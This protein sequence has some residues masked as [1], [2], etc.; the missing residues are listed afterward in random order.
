MSCEA[1]AGRVRPSRS[2][3]RPERDSR[4]RGSTRN[5]SAAPPW[6]WRPMRE[7]VVPTYFTEHEP[8]GTALDRYAAAGVRLVELHG[9]APRTHI[10]L[11]DGAA[12]DALSRDRHGLRLAVHSVHAPYSQPGED[13]WD[14]SQPDEGRRSAALRNHGKVI[15]SAARLGANHVVIHPGVRQRGEGRLE[16]CRASMACL[17]ESAREAGTRVA[18]ENLPPDF[19]GSSV[20]EMIHLLAG[21]DPAAAGVCL[22]TGHAM[23]GGD[24]PVAYVRALGDRIFGLHWHTNDGLGDAHLIPDIRHAEWGEFFTALDAAGC[25]ALVTLEVDFP[26]GTTLN[27]AIRSIRAALQG[28]CRLRSP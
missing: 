21:S 4:R 22:D 24:P 18:L 15:K 2:T 26:P 10:D 28:N 11:T 5:Q 16:R 17:A 25:T 20:A 12:V 8:I 6:P 9:D 7:V 27:E 23:L 14:I 19:L 3:K 1:F 13:A